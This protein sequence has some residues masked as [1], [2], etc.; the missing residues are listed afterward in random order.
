MSA[1]DRLIGKARDYE[2]VAAAT[3]FTVAALILREVAAA[4]DE[5]RE[6]A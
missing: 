1:S 4:L 3:A 2:H 6:A 5:D